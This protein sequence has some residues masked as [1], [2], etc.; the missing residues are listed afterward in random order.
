MPNS[1]TGEA[2]EP[3]GGIFLGAMMMQVVFYRFVKLKLC[4]TLAIKII[5]SGVRDFQINLA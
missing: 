3:T 1:S 4:V 5:L 2:F